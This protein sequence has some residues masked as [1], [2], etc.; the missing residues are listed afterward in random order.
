MSDVSRQEVLAFLQQLEGLEPAAG[1]SQSYSLPVH[2]TIIN[3][4]NGQSPSPFVD[5]IPTMVDILNEMNGFFTNGMQFFLCGVSEVD[6]SA[7]YL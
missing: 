6:N 1:L 7:Y 4:N 3:D 5:I 2:L